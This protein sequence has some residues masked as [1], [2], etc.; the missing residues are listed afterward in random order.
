M[1]GIQVKVRERSGGYERLIW[2][3]LRPTNGEPYRYGSKDE[4][5]R[6]RWMCYPD[7]TSER[8]RV[9]EVSSVEERRVR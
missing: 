1:W 5:E 2:R 8:V 3:D 6:I 7:Q 4:A 9:V